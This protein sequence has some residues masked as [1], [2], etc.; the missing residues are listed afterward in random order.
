MNRLDFLFSFCKLLCGS[1]R[2]EMR[3]LIIAM[4]VTPFLMLCALGALENEWEELNDFEDVPG[5][6]SD[7]TSSIKRDHQIYITRLSC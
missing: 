2:D 5:F 6:T 3:V 7:I 4:A 1:P